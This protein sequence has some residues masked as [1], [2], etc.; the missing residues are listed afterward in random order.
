MK[1]ENLKTRPSTQPHAKF[2]ISYFTEDNAGTY[3]CIAENSYGEQAVEQFVVN[4]KRNERGPPTISVEPKRVE[5]VEGSSST[6]NYIYS[7]RKLLIIF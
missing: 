7:V 5:A 6:L 3:I 4:V 2:E 1:K